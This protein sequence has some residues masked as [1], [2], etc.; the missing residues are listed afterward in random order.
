MVRD[1]I[2]LEGMRLWSTLIPKI[3]ETLQSNIPSLHKCW[4]IERLIKED[5][6]RDASQEDSE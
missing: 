2:N 3:E 5:R 1:K 6:E 4:I